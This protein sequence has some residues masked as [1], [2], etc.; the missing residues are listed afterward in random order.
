[1]K[2]SFP[3]DKLIKKIDRIIFNKYTGFSLLEID[4]YILIKIKSLQY[5]L[6][7]NDLENIK[8]S[9]NQEN[10]YKLELERKNKKEDKFHKFSQFADAKLEKK[11]DIFRVKMRLKGDRSI[12]WE[13]K[14]KSS[15][16]V[17]IKKRKKNR[18]KRSCIY[19]SRSYRLFK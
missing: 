3:P 4:D 19:S 17:D 15:Y 13:E 14:N 10:L 2:N 11:N 1:M 7:K 16:K 9:I 18:S 6:K 5:I 8:I 12:H